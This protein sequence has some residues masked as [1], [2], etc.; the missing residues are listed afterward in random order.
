DGTNPRKTER[1]DAVTLLDDEGNTAEPDTN[2]YVDLQLT[3]ERG[4]VWIRRHSYDGLQSSSDGVQWQNIHSLEELGI[5]ELDAELRVLM[6]ARVPHLKFGKNSDL[7]GV[8]TQI[9]GLDDL[10]RTAEVAGN[11]CMNLRSTATRLEKDVMSKKEQV[12]K[13]VQTVVESSPA[14]LKCW[15]E[16]DAFAFPSRS[17]KTVETFGTHLV[18]YSDQ[19]RE[20]L[21]R[22]LGVEIPSRESEEFQEYQQRLKDLPG[23]VQSAVD[24]LSRKSGAV[25]PLTLGEV[26]TAKEEVSNLKAALSS[27]ELIASAEVAAR[28]DWMREEIGNHRAK[29]MLE[30]SEHFPPDA[31]VC[32][33]CG[34]SLEPVPQVKAQLVSYKEKSC[35]P[36][37]RKDIEDHESG[38]IHRL[39]MI[40][41]AEK[42]LLGNKDLSARLAADWNNL[43][44]ERMPG[45]LQGIAG[46]FDSYVQ[47]LINA[48]SE[49]KPPELFTFCVNTQE[50]MPRA[51]ERLEQEINRCRDFIRLLEALEQNELSVKKMS[52]S[53]ASATAPDSLLSV[54][55]RGRAT[56]DLLSVYE[57]I[58]V[59]LRDI[60][61]KERALEA[62]CDKV[63]MWRSLAQ[64]VQPVKQ[65]ADLVRTEV[66]TQVSSVQPAMS[67][68]YERLYDSEILPFKMLTAG[69]PLN[70]K[71]KGLLNVYLEAGRELVPVGPFANAGRLR[72]LA[73]CFVFAL[74]EKS[75]KTLTILVLDDPALSMDD[76][77]KARFI[78]HL[79][80]PRA[81]EEQVLLG[82]HYEKFFD[83]AKSRVP[84]ATVKRLTP[85][86]GPSSAVAFEPGQWLDRVDESLTKASSNWIEC[87]T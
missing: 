41:P 72:A 32:P 42:R 19:L 2:Y 31:N 38:L 82:T 43:K 62:V 27:F 21:A 6:P 74:L 20:L 79:V 83:D 86:R 57:G 80:V 33:V 26:D 63:T 12:D 10:E 75:Q 78:T 39:D 56:N 47:Q 8:F 25:L 81:Q 29:L 52:E 85:R 59:H 22:D 5:S 65:L 76:Q 24:F 49:A 61:A 45:L 34:Q 69:H 9:V 87:A 3:S 60:Y 68:Y 48:C 13:T 71:A 77:H 40:I 54:I 11:L 46:R 30:A 36:C 64:L 28:M 51:Y 58:R 35:E 17:L 73:L 44:Q 53:I 84:H 7:I 18:S 14:E 50:S 66:V 4:V 37:L 55:S 16:Y 70:P 67:A 23:Q 1:F 15:P